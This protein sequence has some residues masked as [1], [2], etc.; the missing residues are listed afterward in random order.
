MAIGRV[1]YAG[2]GMVEPIIDQA[3]RILHPK[4]VEENAGPGGQSDEAK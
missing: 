4:R 1:E 3:K 2:V